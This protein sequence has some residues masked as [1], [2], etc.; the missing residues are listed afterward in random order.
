MDIKKIEKVIKLVKA[1]DVKKFKYKD[2]DNEIELDFTNGASQQYSQQLSQ[3][4]QQDNIK[5]YDEKQESISNDQQEIKSPMVGTFFLQ[6]SKELTEPKIKVGDTV[7][8]GDV[9]GYIE[10]MKVMNEVTTDVSGEVTE[11]LV[12]HG[13]NVEYDQLLVRVK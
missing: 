10:A 2:A 13:D 8:E 6:D 1:N 11:I 12:E 7:T 3:D 9:I 4:I 5:S